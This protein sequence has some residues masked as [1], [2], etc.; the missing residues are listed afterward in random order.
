LIVWSHSFLGLMLPEQ[1]AAQQVLEGAEI[2]DRLAPA[3]LARVAVGIA[4]EILPPVEIHVGFQVGLPG[5]F[6]GGLEG[7]HEHAFGAQLLGELVGGEGLA[8]AHLGVPKEARHGVHIL[9]P[10]GMEVGVRLVY[11]LGLLAAHGEGRMMR[12][13]EVLAR[14]QLGEH[15]FYV[16]HRAAHPFQFDLLESLV[17]ECGA[18]LVV[19]EEGSVLPHGGRVEFDTVVLDG[20]GLELF[21][22][23]LLYVA[24]GLAHLEQSLVCFVVNRVGVDARLGFRLGGEDFLDGFSHHA[25]PSDES[26]Y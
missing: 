24:G 2:D 20:G 5:I 18:H 15:G 11:G 17:R 8:K 3:D 9:L 6:D 14:A 16:R 26:C 23:A 1:V 22:D 10:D 4:R 13:G 21:F 12:A 7:D 25:L 19:A